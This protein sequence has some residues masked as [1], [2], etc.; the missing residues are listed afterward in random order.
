MLQLYKNIKTKRTQLGITQA[1][2]AQKLGYADKSMISK[3]ESGKVDLP[4]SKI[5]EFANI[6]HVDASELMGN[7]GVNLPSNQP[8]TLAAH[9]DGAEYTEDELEEIKNFAAFV[10]GKRK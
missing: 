7:D 3:I 6:L 2:L 1:E 9:F 5:I 8:T 4:L 10:K